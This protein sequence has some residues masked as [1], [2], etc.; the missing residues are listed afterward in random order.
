MRKKYGLLTILVILLFS[1]AAGVTLAARSITSEKASLGISIR[2]VGVQVFEEN[3]FLH[4]ADPLW[5]NSSLQE[6]NKG[7]KNSTG[8]DHIVPGSIIRLGRYVRN[9]EKNGYD[10]Y[11]RVVI[12][13]KWTKKDGADVHQGEA[14]ILYT[15]SGKS[16]TRKGNT[17]KEERQP[18]IG[19]ENRQKDSGK[20]DWQELKEGETVN[21]WMITHADDEQITMYY[22]KPLAPNENTTDF[23]SGIEFDRQMGADF[24]DAEYELSYQVTAVQA[25]NSEAAIAAELG[26]FAEFAPDGTMVAVSETGKGSTSANDK[27]G[28]KI[29]TVTLT[30]DDLLAYDRDDKESEKA[31]LNMAPGDERT[32]SVEIVN[33]NRHNAWFY[34]SEKTM[35][36]L[37]EI[38]KSYGGAYDFSVRAGKN[39]SDSNEIFRKSAGGYNINLEADKKGLSEIT[40]LENYKYIAKLAPEERVNI[41]ISLALDGEGMDSNERVDY[42]NANGLLELSFG[43]YY[44][45]DGK[46]VTVTEHKEAPKTEVITKMIEPVVKAVQS[47]KTGDLPAAGKAVGLLVAGGI[48]VL[49]GFRKRKERPE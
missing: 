29:Q 13:K 48:C 18:N 28:A 44:E 25:E 7:E 26:V 47:V 46:A 24:A 41:Y 40:E 33:Q 11:V 17:G 30:K 8:K 3:G 36:E 16:Q 23:L 37:E 45:E 22:T 15:S 12:D 10:V 19:K 4:E 2:N 38:G 34:I 49:L 42:S 35:D 6:N 32:V 31:F 14:D 43:A 9:T 5:G 20:D 39:V 21:G 27:M 1:A